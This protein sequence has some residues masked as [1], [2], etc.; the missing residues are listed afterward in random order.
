MTRLLRRLA[1]TSMIALAMAGPTARVFCTTEALA[2]TYYQAEVVDI[3]GTKYFPAVKDALAK[4]EKSID[5]VMY[6]VSLKPQDTSSEVYQLVNELISAHKRGVKVGVILDQSIGFTQGRDVNRHCFKVLK[7]A[8]ISVRYD[9][10]AVYT[11]AKVLVI[12]NYMV[13]SGSS[14]WSQSAL[15]RNFEVNTLIKSREL[16]EEIIASIK[17]IKTAEDANDE[18]KAQGKGVILSWKFLED[19]R[20]AG[21]M[22]NKHYE[23]A[24]D[25]YLFLLRE[26]DGNNQGRLLL[27]YE[28]IADY[29]GLAVKMT[30]EGYR[31]QINK[32][33]KKLKDDYGLIDVTFH[34][35]KEAEVTLLDYDNPQKPY[36]VPNNWHFVIPYAYWDYGWSAKLSH[37]AKSCYLIN[38]AYASVSSASP[39]WFSSREALVKRFNISDNAISAGMQE[40]RILNLIDA[41]Y[42]ALEG[43]SYEP[44]LAK[45]YKILPLY[46]PKWLE[47]EWDR[48]ELEFGRTKLSEAKAYASVVFKEND[49]LVVEDIILSLNTA[50]KTVVKRAFAVVAR[51]RVGNPKRCYEYVKGIIERMQ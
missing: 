37:G 38:L 36:Q 51:K 14:N 32:S 8:G 1:M 39:W 41:A 18:D 26:F 44:N 7:D 47:G 22:M 3:S 49:P 4:A 5:M 48:L 20:F 9:N 13:V 34:F 40:L 43:P 27:D 42:D 30:R 23:R 10:I 28:K 21:K 12:D 31:R 25:L 11:H 45:S 33:L 19:P 6:Q 46:D 35:N 16:A 15:S 24:L 2:D 50:G 17:S 29:L